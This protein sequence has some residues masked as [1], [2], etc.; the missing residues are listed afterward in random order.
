MANVE[1]IKVIF[2]GDAAGVDQASKKAS[3]ALN[4]VK[5]SSGQATVALTDVSRV[6]SDMPYGIRGVANN[7][8][9]LAASMGRVNFKD[10][11]KGLAGPGGMIIGLS[12]VTSLATAAEMK[13]GSLSNAIDALSQSNGAAAESQRDLNKSFQE[14]VG[15]VAGEISKIQALLSIA[16]DE[17]LSKKARQEAIDSLNKEY[18]KYLP[19]LTQ[20]NINTQAVTKAVDALT[21]SLIRQ[22]K[23]RGLQD[24]ISKEAQKQAELLNNSL[25]E[26]LSTWDNIKIAAQAW[27]DPSKRAFLE[28]T[29]GA[30]AT[31]E[32]LDK[33]SKKIDFFET[34]LKELLSTE[35]IEGTLF[36]DTAKLKTTKVEVPELNLKVARVGLTFSEMLVEKSSLNKAADQL[37]QINIGLAPATTNVTEL[38][39]QAG[40]AANAFGKIREEMLRIQKVGEQV[41]EFLTTQLSGAFTTLF[42]NI[43]N[44][45]KNAMQEFGQAIA[46]VVKR[47]IAAAITAALF[48][49]IVSSVTGGFG[50]A[51]QGGGFL[52][53]F[54]S[55]F[56]QLGGLKLARGGITT[57]PTLA[58]IGDNPS[59]REAVIPLRAGERLGDIGGGGVLRAEFQRDQMV[60]WLEQGAKKLGRHG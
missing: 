13:Y 30:R 17:T 38:I 54:K 12:L 26:N 31:G 25:H 45:G 27:M 22:A 33:S 39:E 6:I 1:G 60:I 4:T 18:D 49:A 43:M 15:S 20:E 3:N 2:S 10:F 47:L 24:L 53:N 23:A 52:N 55:L 58:M 44:G 7:I 5:K 57:G 50:A 16:R 29:K 19:K 56:G 9:Q 34:K 32:A 48:A 14:A 59:G 41:G 37:G 42:E 51:A 46:G 28:A 35:A 8:E 21:A 40:Q 11:L 36:T